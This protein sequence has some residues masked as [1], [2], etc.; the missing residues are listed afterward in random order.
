M[1]ALVHTEEVISSQSPSP[2]GKETGL[3][4]YIAHRQLPVARS[5]EAYTAQ[6]V[7]ISFILSAAIEETLPQDPA[8]R[9]ARPPPEP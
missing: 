7:W 9:L 2:H 4:N 5:Q 6:S 8:Y 1:G 3:R